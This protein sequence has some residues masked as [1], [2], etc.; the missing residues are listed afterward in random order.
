MNI[1]LLIYAIVL[2]G[3]S[4]F[5]AKLC[6]TML[7]NASPLVP[8]AIVG[9]IVSFGLIMGAKHVQT[10]T[11]NRIVK[12]IE[13]LADNGEDSFI[14]LADFQQLHA[15]LE[16]IHGVLNHNSSMLDGILSG[17]PSPFLLVDTNGKVTRSNKHTMDMV[18]ID[19]PW[20]TCIG[21]SLGEVFYNDPTR[22]TVVE[23][24]M[25][26]NRSFH[27][28]EVVITG[29]KGGKRNVLY[30][31]FPIIDHKNV[32]IGGLCIYVDMTDLKRSE[33]LNN[34]KTVKLQEL[35]KHLTEMNSEVA[36]VAEAISS[37]V[38]SGEK[39]TKEAA[40]RLVASSNAM[41][42]M[43]SAVKDVASNAA[44]ASRISQETR[45]KAQDGAK[46]VENSLRRIED[47]HSTSL[48]LKNDMDGL[49]SSAQAI[50]QIMS[51]ISE[52]ADQTN[53]LAL[54]AAIEA[55]RAGDAGRGFAVVADEVRKLA[56]KT[57]A[58]TNEVGR[59]IEAITESTRKSSDS[60]DKAVLMIGEANKFGNESGEALNGIVS[61]A[62][63][64][65]A[66]IYAIATASEE[67][68][69]SCDGV[70][71][72]IEEASNLANET[73]SIMTSIHEHVA[74]LQ[75]V[76]ARIQELMKNTDMAA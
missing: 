5:L 36:N 4:L 39:T 64:T 60:V 35:L 71:H 6:S 17:M 31:V 54:N 29:H 58:S 25:A 51:V 7:P 23:R 75:S 30:N 38:N 48:E 3:I 33:E 41:Q 22:K 59:A 46:V 43:N 27:D 8:C 62:E 47:V 65:S 2:I 11:I 18:E 66:Q 52:I 49:N 74:A 45:Q 72:S 28:A 37:S 32:V 16:K 24:A 63:H 40:S 76:V 14:E 70:N 55:A 73:A 21:K 19:A 20:E 57:M 67:Q 10:E 15:A 50:S 68:S 12:P 1:K 13:L 42:E 44:E 69:A 56:E 34:E 53:L 61:I 9:I 26:E